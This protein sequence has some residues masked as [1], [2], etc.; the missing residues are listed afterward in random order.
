DRPQLAD[1]LI[2]KAVPLPLHPRE[3]IGDGVQNRRNNAADEQGLS[4]HTTRTSRCLATTVDLDASGSRSVPAVQCR[5]SRTRSRI[6]SRTPPRAPGRWRGE[7]RPES[8][9]AGADTT[10]RT[11]ETD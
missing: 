4:C 11:R 2:A 7:P 3:E 8:P 1:G 5:E 10:R 6:I 9:M